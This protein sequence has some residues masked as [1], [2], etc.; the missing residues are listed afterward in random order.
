M[1]LAF[2]SGDMQ[3]AEAQSVSVAMLDN[4]F[5]PASLSVAP[6]TTVTWVNRG[7]IIHVATSDTGAF[8]SSVV[9]LGGSYSFRFTTPGTYAYTCI[10]HPVT[11]KGIIVVNAPAPVAAPTVAAAP[12]TVQ[13]TIAAPRPATVA[14][15]QRAAAPTAQPQPVRET[16]TA[17][18]PT[19]TPSQNESRPDDP[20][21]PGVTVTPSALPYVGN[22]KSAMTGHNVVVAPI[23]A[24]AATLAA[25][26]VARRRARR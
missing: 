12:P 22:G 11:M 18:P 1:L 13:A 24:V 3:R 23:I 15:T 7:Q 9:N 17:A 6:G 19:P 21:P 10:I 16:P 4:V 25:A 5:Q 20:P 14:P 8:D 26:A 2:V